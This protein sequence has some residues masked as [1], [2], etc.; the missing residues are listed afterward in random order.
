MKNPVEHF[1][2]IRAAKFLS[3]AATF[4]AAMLCTSAAYG[5]ARGRA[6]ET[7]ALER[8]SSF[9]P[10]GGR[11]LREQGIHL[12]RPFGFSIDTT[13][14]SDVTQVE[15]LAVKF[16]E[17]GGNFRDVSNWVQIGD[18]HISGWNIGGRLD[19]WLLPFLNVFVLGGYVEGDSQMQIRIGSGENAFLLDV[20][21]GFRVMNIGGGASAAINVG[22]FFTALDATY[23]T[24][25]PLGKREG[26]L[27]LDTQ[28]FVAGARFGYAGALGRT[29]F[30][31]WTGISLMDNTVTVLGTEDLGALGTL[32]YRAE[33]SPKSPVSLVLGA[34]IRFTRGFN[35]TADTAFGT[36]GY[37][38]TL[39][40][41][42][43][44]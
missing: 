36:A 26:D 9:L 10:F 41:T 30:S 14:L 2:V 42:V 21:S 19:A 38:V 6:G 7:P 24:T 40:P 4:A 18:V 37:R 44:F 15:N 13:Y 43:R 31:A 22:H 35:L 11:A 12:R 1:A 5:Q 25:I 39:S 29:P 8:W 27:S 32:D 17:D 20:D 34:Q 3:I 23:V 16:R 28:T 33:Q